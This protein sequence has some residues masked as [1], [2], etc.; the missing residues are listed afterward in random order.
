M[1]NTNKQDQ[2]FKK[3]WTEVK[4]TKGLLKDNITLTENLYDKMEKGE[5]KGLFTLKKMPNIIKLFDPKPD[6]SNIK[7]LVDEIGE[8]DSDLEDKGS[9]RSDSS[10]SLMDFDVIC[11]SQKNNV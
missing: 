7:L 4:K 8:S 5:N 9:K 11:N 1:N 6:I 2:K 3:I 10:N